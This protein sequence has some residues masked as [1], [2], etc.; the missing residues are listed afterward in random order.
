MG[1][2]QNGDKVINKKILYKSSYKEKKY[3]LMNTALTSV[4]I[5][6]KLSYQNGKNEYVL[7][8]LDIVYCSKNN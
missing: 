5:I 4:K 1:V 8:I 3:I 6:L 7:L 2:M